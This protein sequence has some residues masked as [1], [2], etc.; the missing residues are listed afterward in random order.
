M[1][2]KAAKKP[3]QDPLDAF[4]EAANA[5]PAKAIAMLFWMAR[6]DNPDFTVTIKAKDLKAFADCTQ[7]LEV[8]PKIQILRPQGAP[9]QEAIPAAGTRRGIP[10]RPASPP[11][12]Y[13]IVQMV[14]QDGNGFV[15]IENNEDDLERQEESRTLLDWKDRAPRI[16]AQ[17]QQEMAANITSNDTISQAIQALKILS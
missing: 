17:L 16:A 5:N 13:V 2:T 3:E 6:F 14:D 8:K 15:P 7:Y 12:P 10:G 4:V 9:A 11:K 1:S